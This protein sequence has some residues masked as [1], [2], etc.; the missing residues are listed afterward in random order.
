MIRSNFMTL[1]LPKQSTAVQAKV[2]A[3]LSSRRKVGAAISER[4]LIEGSVAL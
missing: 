2:P 1:F 4:H 3:V